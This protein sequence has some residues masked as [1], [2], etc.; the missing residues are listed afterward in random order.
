MTCALLY[1][2]LGWLLCAAVLFAVLWAARCLREE[3][4]PVTK[5]TERLIAEIMSWGDDDLV[6]LRHYYP[7]EVERLAA[8]L[9]D[10]PA[11]LSPRPEDSDPAA[12]MDD[13]RVTT[14]G[15][16][17]PTDDTSESQTRDL[18]WKFAE[19]FGALGPL[20][21]SLTL[22]G[23]MERVVALLRS[24]DPVVSDRQ[25]DLLAHDVCRSVL[26]SR[27]HDLASEKLKDR[28]TS[29]MTATEIVSL[30]RQAA[31][32][33]AKET[34]LKWRQN[35]TTAWS[36]LNLD[37][38]KTDTV[39]EGPAPL[40]E[41]RQDSAPML[42][43]RR[44]VKWLEDR[45]HLGVTNISNDAVAEMVGLTTREFF[46]LTLKTRQRFENRAYT[47]LRALNGGAR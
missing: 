9:R 39:V 35:L 8:L 16:R 1:G 6:L 7:A 30:A 3:D 27:E 24:R 28:Q 43:L 22:D 10:G 47:A 25:V 38:K 31:A 4:V 44:D 33:A 32:T 26:E 37:G 17:T 18:V 14:P 40:S 46:D 45:G 20:S 34:V 36:P 12:G 29:Y 19:S 15:P 2:A 23:V 41:L 5:R 21:A 13:T 42:Q 11:P